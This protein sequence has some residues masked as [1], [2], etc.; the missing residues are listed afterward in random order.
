M[1][2]TRRHFVALA[3]AGLGGFA[4]RTR[5]AVPAAED[6]FN[7]RM[8][9]EFHTQMGNLSPGKLTAVAFTP[10]NGWVMVNQSGGYFARGIPDECYA[11]LGEFIK[12]GHVINSIGFPA[13][14]GNR[15]VVA[16][17]KTI[18]ARGIPDECY[19][20][21]LAMLNNHEEVL[22]VAFPPGAGNR[23]VSVSSASFFARG[24]DDECY[25]VMRNLTQGGRKLKR[26]F[27]DWK[28]G[29]VVVAEDEYFARRIDDECYQKMGEFAGN[30]RYLHNI[31]FSPQQNAWSISS[32]SQHGAMPADLVRRIENNLPVGSNKS[33]IWTRMK[34]Y[35]VPGVT[36]ALVQNNALAWSCG[37]G[38]LE[39]GGSNAAHPESR[40]QAASVS[41]PVGSIGVVRLAQDSSAISLGDDV[42]THINNW[43]LGKRSCV[44]LNNKPTINRILCHRGGIIGRGSTSPANVCAGFSSG[45]GGFA[46]YA[47]GQP[48]PSLLQ[49]LNGDGTNSP[50]IEITIEPGT[51]FH[52]SGAG[53]VLLQRMVEDQSGQSFAAYMKAKVL[54]PLGMADSTYALNLPQSWFD[55]GQV[56]SGHGVD[57][58]VIDGKRNSYPESIAAGLYTS[59]NDLAKLIGFLNR[60]YKATTGNASDPLTPQSVKIMLSPVPGEGANWG[61]GYALGNVG[62]GTFFYTHNGANYGFR[63]EFWGYPE[64]KAGFA[65]LVNADDDGTANNLKAEIIASIKSVYGLP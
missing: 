15:W 41:K 5:I 57:G 62:A 25:Q 56:A 6:Y 10:S 12:G 29:W 45:G 26:V 4:L 42:R 28:T 43:T 8:P 17:N 35:K 27:F 30:Q 16:T 61:R 60:A 31:A 47:A 63:S 18:F 24:I 1:T 2:I 58:A 55:E 36:I 39:K 14:G 7:R 46:G 11:K 32:R 34:N 22:H 33:D 13:E 38:F 50:K 19:Q 59:V 48:V 53:F 23:W 21:L 64:L 44:V 65:V 54:Q 37:Y 20:K 3:G 52:Y 40:F 9:D 51:Q 49:V